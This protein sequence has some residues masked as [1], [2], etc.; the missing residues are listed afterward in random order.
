MEFKARARTCLFLASEAEM[1]AEVYTGLLPDSEIETVYRPDPAGP[2]L[3]VE[4]TLAGAPFMAMNGN[5]EPRPSHMTSI[6]VLTEGQ[7]ETDRL[8]DALTEGGEESQC[9]WLKDRFGVHWQIVPKALPR[10]MAEGGETAQKVS[11]A[12]MGMKKIVIADLEAA[13]RG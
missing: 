9:G 7:A 3:V 11:G 2:A 1:A 6:S 8:W 13:A 10:L 4:F 5:P 12:L